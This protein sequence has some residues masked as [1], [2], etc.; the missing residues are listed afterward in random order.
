M[1]KRTNIGKLILLI[2]TS[3]L[4]HIN[5]VH[6]SEAW[7]LGK[8][9]LH[10]D[11]DGAQTDYLVFKPNG[12]VISTGQNGSIEGIYQL[13]PDSVKAVFTHNDKDLIATFHFNKQRTEL[14]IVTSH[15]GRESIYRKK[16]DD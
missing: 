14:R 1:S 16:V 11:P 7:L 4:L 6:A 10:Y 2:A 12:D 3:L 9:Q 5:S 8:W 13:N 15:S